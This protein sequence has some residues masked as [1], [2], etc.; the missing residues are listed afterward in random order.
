MESNT[1]S[2]YA[3]LA[4]FHDA[5]EC[6]QLQKLTHLQMSIKKY[7]MGHQIK[8]VTPHVCLPMPEGKA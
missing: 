2:K 5:A 3:G 6:C 8:N 7:S 1:F 4:N